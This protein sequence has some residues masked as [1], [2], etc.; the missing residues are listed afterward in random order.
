MRLVRALR[1]FHMWLGV[2][3]A[4][5]LAVLALTGIA[6]NHTDSLG[7]SRG[8]VH[9]DWVLDAWGVPLPEA[10]PSY[11]AGDAAVSWVDGRLYVDGEALPGRHPEPVGAV[12]TSRLLVLGFAESI[13]LLTRNARLV[14]E[15]GAAEGMHG[16]IRRV[17]LDGAGRPVFDTAGGL[18]RADAEF[19][20][21]VPVAEKGLEV[22]WSAPVALEPAQRQRLRELARRVTLSWERVLLDI[23]SG[24][25]AGARGPL[26]VD[27]LAVGLLLLQ[28]T[29]VVMWLRIR[30]LGRHR[31]Q[32]RTAGG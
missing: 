28:G 12:A 25:V 26:L 32:A 20:G 31:R 22:A 1:T 3:A 23:H 5:F 14:E 11:A 24:R 27:A 17:G 29:G 9:W 21:M 10:G 16:N 30:R 7:L 13:M 2:L 6:L 18:F 19:V 4:V 8:H 15:I